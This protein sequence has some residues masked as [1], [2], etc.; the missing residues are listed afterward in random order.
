MHIR[1]KD[2]D[3]QHQFLV[4]DYIDWYCVN[5]K[6]ITQCSDGTFTPAQD[7]AC[8]LVARILKIQFA[9]LFLLFLYSL[10]LVS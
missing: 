10:D 8:F 7:L 9:L 1:E 3:G 5:N 2:I 6:S 4:E